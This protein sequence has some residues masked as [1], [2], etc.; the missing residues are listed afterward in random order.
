MIVK[1]CVLAFLF[2]ALGGGSMVAADGAKAIED[3]VRAVPHLGRP[4]AGS[5][6][7]QDSVITWCAADGSWTYCEVKLTEAEFGGA[8]DDKRH[9]EKLAN[10]YSPVLGKYCEP[11]L[12]QPSWF[13]ENYQILR[14]VW[15]AARTTSSSI[16]FLLPKSNASLWE[17]AHLVLK[18]L[19][20]LLAKRVRVASTEEVL[21]TLAES[22]SLS[23]RLSA[24]A[25][26]LA[27]KYVPLHTAT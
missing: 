12:L 26:L 7:G 20:P 22:G 18:G 9:R 15:L 24:Q 16:L 8:P 5:N 4:L 3:T 2:L 6:R 17:R 19:H 13:F 11:T 1:R 23:P 21:R 14:N 27:E 25:E 10:I